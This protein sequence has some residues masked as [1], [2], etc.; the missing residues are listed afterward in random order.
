[1][2]QSFIKCQQCVRLCETRASSLRRPYTG[3][4][5]TLGEN[6][7]CRVGLTT[8]MD[9]SSSSKVEF[10]IQTLVTLHNRDSKCHID[11]IPIFIQAS[12]PRG[13]SIRALGRSPGQ[14]SAS[15][16]LAAQQQKRQRQH[17]NIVPQTASPVSPKVLSSGEV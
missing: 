1:M 9:M 16:T 12:L 2:G 5:Q 3:I 14:F 13:V 4:P 8:H 7:F 6:L 17:H 11:L 15:A 10:M